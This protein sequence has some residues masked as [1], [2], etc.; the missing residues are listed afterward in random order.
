MALD[1]LDESWRGSDLKLCRLIALFL[2]VEVRVKLDL[3]VTEKRN[4]SPL[5]SRSNTAVYILTMQ[6]MMT[7][8]PIKE[9]ALPI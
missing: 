8:A 2:V 9:L 3:D 5:L 7:Q 6:T 1:L 4:R